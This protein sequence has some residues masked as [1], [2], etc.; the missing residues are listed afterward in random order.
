MSRDQQVPESPRLSDLSERY[1]P[2][3]P[4]ENNET[5]IAP[6]QLLPILPSQIPIIKNFTIT[7]NTFDAD[8]NPIISFLF[9]HKHDEMVITDL[10]YYAFNELRSNESVRHFCTTLKQI[11]PHL[12]DQEKELINSRDHLLQ[13]PLDCTLTSLNQFSFTASPPSEEDKKQ[14]HSNLRTILSAMHH[15]G[16][17]GFSEHTTQHAVNLKQIKQDCFICPP[18]FSK[19]EAKAIFKPDHLASWYEIHLKSREEVAGEAQEP[20]QP[21]SKFDNPSVNPHSKRARS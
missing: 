16:A 10:L 8:I 19:K 4:E 2:P 11:T 15:M 17:V 3:I 13:Y 6:P 7:C 20:L 21:E 18:Y 5:P 12:N 14:L 1:I 9:Y